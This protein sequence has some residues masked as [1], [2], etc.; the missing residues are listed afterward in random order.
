MKRRSN[1]YGDSRDRFKPHYVI[2]SPSR[3]AI[4]QKPFNTVEEAVLEY[5][6]QMDKLIPEVREAEDWRIEERGAHGVKIINPDT[7]KVDDGFGGF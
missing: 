4:W 2:F 5:R 3:K 1:D 6:A 7:I